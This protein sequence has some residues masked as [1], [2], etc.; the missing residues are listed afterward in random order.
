MEQKLSPDVYQFCSHLTPAAREF[1]SGEA[2]RPRMESKGCFSS[3]GEGGGFGL[4][5]GAG[6]ALEHALPV[7]FYD[8]HVETGQLDLLEKP[9]CGFSPLPP[10]AALHGK[11]E[12]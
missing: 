3:A 9:F 8:H 6:E 5:G 7:G 4:R 10:G 12:V 1:L 2:P 11:G